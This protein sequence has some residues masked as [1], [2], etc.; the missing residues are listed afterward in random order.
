MVVKPAILTDVTKC[1]GCEKCVEACK[2]ANNLGPDV[3][4]RDANPDGLSATRWTSIISMP[5]KRYV[6][7]HCR[8]CLEPA[9]VSACPVGAL[10]KTKEGPVIY[11]AG[12][13]IG[14]RYCMMACPY[15]VPRYDWASAV[16]YVRKCVM[17]YPRLREGLQPACTEACPREATVFGSRDDLIEEARG[18]IRDNPGRYIKRVFGERDVGGTSVLYV[19]DIAL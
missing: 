3:P 8:H 11:D 6:R 7:K 10:R 17:C 9:C 14:C 1:I 15:G 4:L 16:P 18:R 2:T 12:R 19:S 5:G 13:C